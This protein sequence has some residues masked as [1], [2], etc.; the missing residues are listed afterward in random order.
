MKH[1]ELNNTYVGKD[2]KNVTKRFQAMCLLM[3]DDSEKYSGFL[4]ELKSTTLLGTENTQILQPPHMTYCAITRSQNH[5]N[6]HIH[7][8]NLDVC[9]EGQCK[10]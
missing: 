10:Q 9:P 2:D 3:S 7:H 5:N 8:C 6:K 4:D 1:M